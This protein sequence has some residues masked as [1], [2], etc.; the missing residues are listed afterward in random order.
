MDGH[1]SGEPDFN[2]VINDQTGFK[3]VYFRPIWNNDW[4][5]HIWI[6]DALPQFHGHALL[7]TGQ[8]GLQFLMDLPGGAEA[9]PGS[10]MTFEGNKMESNDHYGE[11]QLIT[12]SETDKRW[13]YT[14]ELSSIQMADKFTPTFHYF[15]DGS[16]EEITI[17][18]VAYS[19]EDYIKWGLDNTSGDMLAI[20][21][22]LADYGYYS[23]PYLSAQNGWTIGT[24]YAAFTTRYTESF[25]YSEVQTA[26]TPY[27]VE[28]DITGFTYRVSF[29]SF[30]KFEIAFKL[31]EGEEVLL[32]G[33]TPATTMG[34]GYTIV[35]ID[36]ITAK[37]L[38][39]THILK[40]GDKTVNN[41]SAMTY[42]YKMLSKSDSTSACKN[43]MCAFYNYGA[44][45]GAFSGN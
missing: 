16:E 27:A 18:D 36:R 3:T 23:Q 9:W 14:I 20:I 8:I 6:G 30:T 24:D 28:T 21:R 13:A 7:L 2:Y 26:L 43:L 34:N 42:A 11:P 4:H 19:A 45:C 40:V 37:Q 1:T 12:F 10:Y 31:A 32:D 33:T 44:A 39:K 29:G 15:V 5:G 38:T 41:I 22:S 17:T 25:N 35:T